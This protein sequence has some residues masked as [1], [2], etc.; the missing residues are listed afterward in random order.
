M[1]GVLE[2]LYLIGFT[3]AELDLI[4]EAIYEMK[5][6]TDSDEDILLI[7]SIDNK[8]YHASKED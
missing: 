8:I 4:S 7:R 6:S 2:K 5:I 1:N 3:G